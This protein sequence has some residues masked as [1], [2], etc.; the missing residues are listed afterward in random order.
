MIEKKRTFFPRKRIC[1]STPLLRHNRYYDIKRFQIDLVNLASSKNFDNRLLGPAK[2]NKVKIF[3]GPCY[4]IKRV[5]TFVS[6]V[7]ESV[8]VNFISQNF[9]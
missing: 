9:A 1:C 5:L 8:L 7:Q 6:G 3:S 2:A 4:I